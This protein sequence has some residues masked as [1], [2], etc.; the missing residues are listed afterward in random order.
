MPAKRSFLRALWVTSTKLALPTVCD[1]AAAHNEDAIAQRAVQRRYHRWLSPRRGGDA[2][3][4][5]TRGRRGEVVI[6]CGARLLRPVIARHLAHAEEERREEEARQDGH[7][8]P[9]VHRLCNQRDPCVA[10]DASAFGRSCAARG[11]PLLWL[12]VGWFGRLAV[13]FD[14]GLVRV[15]TQQVVGQREVYDVAWP[16]HAPHTSVSPAR[17]PTETVLRRARFQQSRGRQRQTATR[18]P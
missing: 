5:R 18:L 11:A 3:S 9:V 13:G 8:T 4:S 14:G 12:R 10:T 2:R 6:S 16:R 15:P 7:P 17:D 1:R